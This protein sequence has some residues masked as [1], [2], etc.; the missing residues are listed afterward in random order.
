MA[1]VEAP[2]GTGYRTVRVPGVLIAGKTGT[3]ESSPQ[4][5][6]HAWFVGY[7]PADAPRYVIIVVLEHGGSGSRAAGPV[8]RE[9]VRAMQTQG[10]L[11]GAATVPVD[12]PEL[13][14]N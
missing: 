11:D 14:T 12:V 3:A 10:L 13:L 6:D 4:K 5:P 7:V 2:I 9:L 8:V 1:V